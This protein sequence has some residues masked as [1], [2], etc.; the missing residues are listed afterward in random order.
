MSERLNLR[1]SRLRPSGRAPQPPM[2]LNQRPSSVKRVLSRIERY[3][4]RSLRLSAYKRKIEALDDTIEAQYSQE[5]SVL[6]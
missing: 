2:V 4:E 6:N 3:Q 1:M 5:Q